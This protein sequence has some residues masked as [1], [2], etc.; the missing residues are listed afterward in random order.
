[1]ASWLLHGPA[2]ARS[3]AAPRAPRMCP[4]A[5]PLLR[6]ERMRILYGIVGEGMGHA[7]R[8]RVVIEHLTAQGHSVI[9]VSSGQA[10][11][12][13]SAALPA[14][15]V[16]AIEGLHL[17]YSANELEIARSLASTAK[18]LPSALRRSQEA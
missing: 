2:R 7:T 3:S 17:A 16:L 13:L 4:G 15:E 11:R 9:A 8:S 5:R 10:A 14:V 1:M 12:A 6:R 18:T